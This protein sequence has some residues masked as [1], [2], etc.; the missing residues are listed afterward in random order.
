MSAAR[1]KVGDVVTYR[2]MA[3][4]GSTFV[5]VGVSDCSWNPYKLRK[6]VAPYP[7]EYTDGRQSGWEVIS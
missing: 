5:V 7:I 3:N 6:A 2:D 4:P 1:W